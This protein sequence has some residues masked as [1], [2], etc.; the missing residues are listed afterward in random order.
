[1]IASVID[2]VVVDVNDAVVVVV[3]VADVADPLDVV[4]DCDALKAMT[5]LFGIV[6]M[7]FTK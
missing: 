3:P 5:K 1:M 2:A 4:I 6:L 7:N